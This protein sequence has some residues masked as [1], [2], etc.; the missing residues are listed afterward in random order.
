M[1]PS[2]ISICGGSPGGTGRLGADELPALVRLGPARLAD[3]R[4]E[5]RMA[6]DARRV[7][8]ASVAVGDRRGA[9]GEDGGHHLRL[10]ADER[11]VRRLVLGLGRRRVGAA[12]GRRVLVE[13]HALASP[14]AQVASRLPVA[15]ERA[16]AVL[17]VVADRAGSSRRC[18]EA[19]RCR[20]SGSARWSTH[21]RRA[22]RATA[23]ADTPGTTKG[24]TRAIT[25][26]LRP[27]RLPAALRYTGPGEVGPAVSVW[28]SAQE[29]SRP[30]CVSICCTTVPSDDVTVGSVG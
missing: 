5:L 19:R 24:R 4:E 8:G 17:D 28:Q 27:G 16:A 6:R 1:P 15:V 14:D 29:P 21:R 22:P 25:R 20:C 9:A 11:A 26:S 2:P 30:M 7:L 12:R 13:P 23:S 18:R 3:E 10:E